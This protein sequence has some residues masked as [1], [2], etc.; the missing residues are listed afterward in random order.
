[1]GSELY[2]VEFLYLFVENLGGFGMAGAAALQFVAGVL[3]F[4]AAG[5]SVVNSSRVI[6]AL[7]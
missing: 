3:Q 4:R 1:V 6:S 2:G 7:V 5:Q